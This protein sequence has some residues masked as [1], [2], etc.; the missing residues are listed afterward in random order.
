MAEMKILSN[1][2][3]MSEYNIVFIGIRE[4]INMTFTLAQSHRLTW[5]LE[6]TG[7][8]LRASGVFRH[9]K[10]GYVEKTLLYFLSLI[11]TMHIIVNSC[12]AKFHCIYK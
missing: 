4:H 3:N 1:F 9:A 11:K 10:L 2:I 8:N 6:S 5:R 7:A 12:I